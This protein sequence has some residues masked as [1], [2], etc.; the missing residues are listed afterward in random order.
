MPT[1]LLMKRI[2][3]LEVS[4]HEP[5]L[6]MHRNCSLSLPIVVPVMVSLYVFGAT[7]QTA[8]LHRNSM[9]LWLLLRS[10]RRF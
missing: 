2:P 5:E 4:V 6:M 8:I 9:F 7:A 1:L 3:V 10:E